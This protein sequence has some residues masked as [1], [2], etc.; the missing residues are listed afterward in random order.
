MEG[1]SDRQQYMLTHRQNPVIIFVDNS[2]GK[3]ES[4]DVY[5]IHY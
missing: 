1:H 5:S 2:I 3:A 4:R